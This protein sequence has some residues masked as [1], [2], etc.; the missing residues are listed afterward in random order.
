MQFKDPGDESLSKRQR[1]LLVEQRKKFIEW[2]EKPSKF[3]KE[4]KEPLCFEREIRFFKNDKNN[5]PFG[6]STHTSWEKF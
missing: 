6:F 4:P 1:E 2:V 5:K 3:E